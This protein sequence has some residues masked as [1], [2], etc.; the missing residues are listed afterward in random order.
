[1]GEIKKIANQTVIYGISSIVPRLL[2]YFLVPLYTYIFSNPSQYGIVTELY[3]YSSVLLIILTYGM[4]TGFFRYSGKLKNPETVFGTS[5]LGLLFTTS[6]FV[7][8]SLLFINPISHAL[9]YDEHPEYLIQFIFILSFDTLCAIPFTKLRL[10]NRALKFVFLKIFNV[11]INIFLNIFFLIIC[12]YLLKKHNLE[13]IKYI[14]NPSIGIGYIFLSNLISSG[15]LFLVLIPE[16]FSNKLKFNFNIY[17]NMLKY[18][19]PL[20]IAGLAGTINETID[21]ILIVRLIP[22]IN[23]ARYQL[24]I[25]GA[26]I[27]IAVLMTL[28]TQAFR[29]AFEPYFFN[30]H[31]NKGSNQVYGDIMKYFVIFG[32]FIFMFVTQYIDLFKHFINKSYHEGLFIVPFFLFSYL[33]Y[34]IL[35]N[36]SVWYKLQDKTFYG[37]IITLIGAFVSLVLNYIFIPKYGY[38]AC[39]FIHLLSYIIMV[40]IS[41]ILSQKYL[42]VNYHPKQILFYFILAIALFLIGNLIKFD[43]K[44]LT[45]FI[46]TLILFTFVTIIAVRE[47]IIKSLFHGN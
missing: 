36:L 39:T 32:L 28:F 34:G 10:H 21:R 25:Y 42:P 15:I 13:F 22:D 46:H 16:I 20:F 47:N 41:Y 17:K 9:K 18:S 7:I 29:F 31:A 8:L 35:F 2:N 38:I 33:F 23:I 12:P 14:Y 11:I 4:E 24:G 1:M 27:K 5:F 45:I 6:I 26:N 43:S 3:T 40:I 44:I 19:I 37:T 30:H